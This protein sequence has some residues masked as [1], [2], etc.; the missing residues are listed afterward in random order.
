MNLIPS[1]LDKI[2][3]GFYNLWAGKIAIVKNVWKLKKRGH[4][5]LIFLIV[6]VSKE[7]E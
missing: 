1:K 7:Y 3:I 2:Q 6:C 4:E 5:K